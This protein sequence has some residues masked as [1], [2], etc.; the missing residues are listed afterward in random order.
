MLEAQLCRENHKGKHKERS[1]QSRKDQEGTKLRGFE[2]DPKTHEYA[3]EEE[4]LKERVYIEEKK[5]KEEW[6]NNELI[7][8]KSERKKVKKAISWLPVMISRRTKRVAERD[9]PR[10]PPRERRRDTLETEERS[11]V[12]RE[13]TGVPQ[14]EGGQGS[15]TAR[16]CEK[17]DDPGW[18]SNIINSEIAIEEIKIRN[19]DGPFL[20]A[21]NPIFIISLAGWLDD[22]IGM[23]RMSI[24][25]QSSTRSFLTES[26]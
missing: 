19:W 1:K 20:F 17:M 10:E 2:T 8:S 12:T 18:Q 16:T 24:S 13:Y 14:W 25:D 15:R 6:R 26:N 5:R 9:T 21:Y 23:I 22:L 4:V 3:Q 11:F 7:G